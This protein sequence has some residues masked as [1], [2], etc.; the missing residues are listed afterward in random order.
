MPLRLGSFPRSVHAERRDTF[1]VSPRP[2]RRNRCRQVTPSR[3]RADTCAAGGFQLPGGGG[4]TATSR[5]AIRPRPL[6]V[7]S[8]R[9]APPFMRTPLPIHSS[10]PAAHSAPA[11]SFSGGE[12]DRWVRYSCCAALRLFLVLV[13]HA[14]S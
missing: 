3:P 5:G 7:H 4:A 2:A 6:P 9:R 11:V 10:G 12:R 1:I 8:S 14:V 13:V